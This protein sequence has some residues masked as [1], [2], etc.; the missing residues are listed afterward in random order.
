MPRPF[1]QIEGSGNDRRKRGMTQTNT[2]LAS[3]AVIALTLGLS[4]QK[5]APVETEQPRSTGD[6]VIVTNESAL[7]AAESEE[8]AEDSAKM[9]KEEGTHE[10]DNLGATP[11]NDTA[12]IDQPGRRNPTPAIHPVA[13]AQLS[14]NG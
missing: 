13:A 11:E 3:V 4:G 7:Q 9:G 10:G 14:N 6:I 8:N 1:I 2:V 12:K 5:L